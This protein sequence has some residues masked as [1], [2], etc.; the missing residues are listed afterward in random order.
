MS[1][2]SWFPAGILLFCILG[3]L[4]QAPSPSPSRVPV[5]VELFTSEGCSSCP[6]ADTLLVQLNQQ[7][8]PGVQTIALGQH[9]DYWNHLGWSDRFSSAKFS[10]RQSA[11]SSQFGLDS[12]YTPQMVVN[13]HVQFVGN[14]TSQAR[15]AIIAAAGQPARAIVAISRVLP[16]NL[17]VEVSGA[18]GSPDVMLAFTEDNLTTEVARGENGGRTL[19]HAAVVRDLRKIGV[20]KN[21][22]FSSSQAIHLLPEW[23]IEN[24]RA[25][26]FLQNPNTMAILGA[27]SMAMK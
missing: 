13:G 14:D 1:S 19:R 26:V 21:G 25:V 15:R 6:P 11:Y 2:K 4:A 18:E 17:D 5:I 7:G 24:V 12:V 16:Q 27:A 20:V 10:H 9:V 8:I 23:R 3:A 22:K